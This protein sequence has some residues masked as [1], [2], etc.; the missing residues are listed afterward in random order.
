MK[1]L[2]TLFILLFALV[3]YSQNWSPSPEKGFNEAYVVELDGHS[4]DAIYKSTLDWVKETFPD[5]DKVILSETENEQLKFQGISG[6]APNQVYFTINIQF[7]DGKYRVT[8]Q[9][10]QFYPSRVDFAT[11]YFYKKDGDIKKQNGKVLISAMNFFTIME[12]GI[13]DNLNK[14]EDD[15]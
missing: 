5:A 2:F 15:W 11:K 10:V 7:K 12:G 8:P 14:D 9:R 1:N 13:K 6:I 3:S 4:A